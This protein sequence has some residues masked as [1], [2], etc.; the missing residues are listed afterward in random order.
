MVLICPVFSFIDYLTS[1]KIRY[2]GYLLGYWL[3]VTSCSAPPGGGDHVMGKDSLA[4]PTLVTAVLVQDVSLYQKI[5]A[6]GTIASSRVH[7]LSFER[8]GVID[9]LQ[10]NNGAH[11][12]KGAV[13]SELH[14]SLEAMAVEEARLNYLQ[15]YYAD[16][17]ERMF[18]NDSAFYKDRWKQVDEKT[19]L[20]SGLP[21]AKVAWDRAKLELRQTVLTAPFSGVISDLTVRPG[22][23]VGANDPL[24]TLYDPQ[25]LEIVLQLLEYDFQK[26]AIGQ[27][28]SIEALA[29]GNRAFTGR[30][31][32][33]NPHVDEAGH[34]S[35]K[36]H[37][38]GEVTGIVPGMNARASIRV[39]SPEKHLLVPL[40][41]VIHKSGRD[42]VFTYEGGLAKWHYV[43]LGNQNGQLIEVLEGLHPGS[44]VITSDVYQLAHDSPVTLDSTSHLS[45]IH[46]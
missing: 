3:A 41:S 20:K 36:V 8:E 7:K 38:Y 1:M 13:V 12:V 34:F 27:Q 15:A 31:T 10:V 22:D 32:E 9:R 26:I 19:A 5:E 40:N 4:Q 17:D 42:V 21:Q 44:Y 43:T 28:V 6:M 39:E 16:E 30:L 25:A 45:A 18:L 2:S 46:L 37:L 11:L 23:H 35:V 14:N 33:I 24:C 29:L